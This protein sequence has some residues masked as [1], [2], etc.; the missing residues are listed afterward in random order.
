MQFITASEAMTMCAQIFMMDGVDGEVLRRM[1]RPHTLAL[2]VF[3][4]LIEHRS[5]VFDGDVIE[6][7]I[8]NRSSH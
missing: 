4:E 3:I 6:L 1:Q 2:N 8:I 5:S 7:H